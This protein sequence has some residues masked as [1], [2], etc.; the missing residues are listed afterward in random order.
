VLTASTDGVGTK[1][2]LA[3]ELDRYDTIGQ[4]LV[5]MSVNDLVCSGSR[6]LFF[7]DYFATG[8]LSTD[9]H[10]VIV[11]GI[12]KACEDVGCALL[13]G[14][15]AEMPGMYQG[16]DFDLAGFAVGLVDRSQ[17]IDGQRIQVG[18]TII[19]IASS[20]FHSNGYSL[21]RK[22]V[23]DRKLNLAQPLPGIKKPLGDLLLQPTHLY[24]PLVLEVMS[25]CDLRG[26]AHITGGGFWDNIPRILP[27]NVQAAIDG[28]SWPR[29]PIMA[30]LQE[31]GGIDN[32][33]MLRVFNCGIGMIFV[34]PSTQTSTVLQRIKQKGFEAWKIGVIEKRSTNDPAIMVS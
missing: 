32:H 18:D 11:R 12:A 16:K 15:T 7:L 31:Q 14:E 30:F 9:R 24:S 28:R 6:P 3:I 29:P 33:E 4:D 23:G 19:G 5:A 8:K 22:I 13:G 25:S 26:I 34:V 21:V 1:L 10:A 2:K 17:I 27:K 20:G